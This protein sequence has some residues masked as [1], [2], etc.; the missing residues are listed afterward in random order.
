MLTYVVFIHE[1]K[2]WV[3]QP[4]PLH[5][6]GRGKFKNVLIKKNSTVYFFLLLFLLKIARPLGDEEQYG[7]H[8]LM[9]CGSVTLE[10]RK[11]NS[12]LATRNKSCGWPMIEY[13]F[14][15][16][17]CCQRHSSKQPFQMQRDCKF[18][19]HSLNNF[20]GTAVSDHSRV[21]VALNLCCVQTL[22]T[23][24]Y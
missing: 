19:A 14:Y 18:I 13:I 21:T 5:I 1:T 8:S 6:C 12:N 15:L 17:F 4:L 7:C 16:L 20:G 24:I 22:K 10:D 11:L 3:N 9:I 2:C 23:L